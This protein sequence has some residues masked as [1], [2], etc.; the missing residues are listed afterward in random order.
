MY[1]LMNMCIH[2]CIR[3]NRYTYMFEIGLTQYMY[4]PARGSATGQR[5]RRSAPRESPE[6]STSPSGDRSSE[7][8]PAEGLPAARPDV[9]KPFAPHALNAPYVSH[10]ASRAW[11]AETGRREGASQ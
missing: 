11:V 8:V 7:Q 4:I 2:I 1:T 5:N 3:V 10:S 9:T 6:S